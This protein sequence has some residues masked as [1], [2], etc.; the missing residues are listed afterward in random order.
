MEAFELLKDALEQCGDA[1]KTVFIDELPWMDTK[2][3]GFVKAVEGFWNGWASARTDIV[4][5]VCGS[6]ASWMTKKILHNRG[7]LF[8]RANRVLQLEPFTL[9]ECEEFTQSE[10]IVMD[11]KD[12][13]SA[14][15]VFGG[16]P[17]YWSLLD[18]RESLSQ[19]I[20]RLFFGNAPVLADEFDRLYR[21]VFSTPEPYLSI[22]TAL[23]GRKAGL[24][25]N[26]IAAAAQGIANNG[27][28]TE[29]L[30]N[31]VSCGFVRKYAETGNTSKDSVFQLIDDYTLFF[32]NFV[33]GYSGRDEQRWSHMTHDRIRVA[34][35]GLAFERV[36]LQH[37]RQIK[38]ALGISGVETKESAWRCA[39]R[40]PD[41][42]GAQI[43]LVI[44]RADRVTNLC[45][46]KFANEAF[47]IDAE[48]AAKLREK[49]GAFKR[50]TG[51]RSNCHL[52]FVTTFGLRRNKYSSIVQSEVTLDDL[53]RREF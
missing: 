51:T 21:S 47:A 7:G 35:E 50:E 18:K 31:L 39:S 17:Y 37:S 48:Y 12:I 27:T 24:T 5:I 9:S 6:A 1:R 8:N 42:R 22:V 36:C 29:M 44:E 45:E 34:W 40:D 19:N 11:R 46:M 4:M 32:F 3:S 20:D 53:F 52:T 30:A 33:Q 14:Y 28:L 49:V 23:S 43:D 15:M 38:A 16:A 25:R 2:N 10:G 26:E 13:V 41:I